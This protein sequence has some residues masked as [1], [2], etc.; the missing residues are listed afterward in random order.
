[1]NVSRPMSR[2][3]TKKIRQDDNEHRPQRPPLAS[4]QQKQSRQDRPLRLQR[5]QR[6]HETGQHFVLRPQQEE[7]GR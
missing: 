2:N 5:Q 1:M 4:D 6:E 7:T 3:G